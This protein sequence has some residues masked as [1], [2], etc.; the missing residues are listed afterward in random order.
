MINGMVVNELLG[1]LLIADTS[2]KKIAAYEY[3]VSILKRLNKTAA[4]VQDLIKGVPETNNVYGVAVY[5]DKQVVWS[6][7]AKVEGKATGSLYIASNTQD[8]KSYKALVNNTG[9]VT[10]VVSEK[11]SIYF[12]DPTNSRLYRAKHHDGKF[13]VDI[14]NSNLNKIYQI[15]VLDKFL[16]VVNADGLSVLRTTSDKSTKGY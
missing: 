13:E 8:P 4:Y 5:K 16:Y 7:Y 14:I 12:L 3:D 9:G 11:S 15:Q 10:S 1:V 2:N 6:S